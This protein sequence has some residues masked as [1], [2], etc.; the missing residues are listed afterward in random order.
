MRHPRRTVRLATLFVLFLVASIGGAQWGRLAAY[1]GGPT[2]N[3]PPPD[4]PLVVRIYYDDIGDLALLEGIDLWEYN[5]LDERYV[6]GTIDYSGYTKLLERGWN[7]VID[8]AAPDQ[9]LD[10]GRPENER[11]FYGDY[12]TVQE[13]NARLEALASVNLP[14][15]TL[16]PYGKSYCL[17]HHGCT[18]PGGDLISGFPLLALRITNENIPGSSVIDGATVT[19]GTKPIFFLMGGTHS[20]EIT[21]PEIAM[22]LIEELLSSYGKDA[23]LTWLVDY[24]EIWVVTTANPDGHRLVE[25]GMSAPY[26]GL[27]FYQRKNANNDDNHDG[28]PDCLVWPPTPYEQYGIDLNRNHSFGWGPPGSSADPCDMTYR[29]LSVASE[30]E[31]AVLET[32]LRGLFADQRGPALDDAA[33]EDTSGILITLHSFSNL[34]LWPWGNST[35]P[36]PNKA[37]LKAIG[38]KFASYNDYLS[39]QP[40]DCLYLT[41]GAVDDWAYGEL[42]IPAYTF[43]IGDQFMPPYAEI[44]SR[45]WP[46]NRPALIYAAKIAGRPYRIVRGPDVVDAVVSGEPPQQLITATIDDSRN[47]H[48]VIA[49]AAYSIDVPVWEE[50]AIMIPLRP[51]DGAFDSAIEMVTGTIDLSN[52]A[53]GQHTL[54]LHGQD[55]LDNWGPMTATFFNVDGTWSFEKVALKSY[56]TPGDMIPYTISLKTNHPDNKDDYAITVTDTLPPELAAV[57]ESIMVNGIVRPE[58]YDPANQTITVEA[59]GTFDDDWGLSITYLGQVNQS[60][61]SG[62]FIL[63]EASAEGT[64]NGDPV[65]VTSATAAVPIIRLIATQ[66][67]PVALT[68]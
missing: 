39:C 57:P 25:L 62:S 37:D 6:L 28:Q 13:L 19:R 16:V 5:N 35:A 45:Q 67:L 14:L 50:D 17:T 18:T 52:L 20:R 56:A 27:P 64:I 3:P 59:T 8:S 42:G 1:R 7:V 53:L 51:I 30:P 10:P 36:A 2:D 31:T 55:A 66:Y 49:A 47:G 11:T 23:D 48:N 65:T 40:T 12:R 58:L 61:P 46:D 29:G 68:P 60:A 44:D 4:P 22:R 9:H 34:V 41:S 43:E 24:H 32:L 54:F 26:S 63:N 21:T 38:D 33:P 15:S